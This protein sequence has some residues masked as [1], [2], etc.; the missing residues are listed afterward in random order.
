M[1]DL[2]EARYVKRIIIGND[3][4]QHLRSSSEI[5]ASVALLNRCLNESPKGVIIG[6]EKNF[7]ILNIGE[8]Q[9]VLQWIVYHVAFRRKPVWLQD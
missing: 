3:N 4:P 1:I 2:T 8:H 7:S 9:V 6:T 5:D